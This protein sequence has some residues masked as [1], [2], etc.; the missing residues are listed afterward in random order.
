MDIPLTSKV[1]D[2]PITPPNSPQGQL[3]V[4]D[5]G[6][7]SLI[8]RFPAEV[9]SWSRVSARVEFSPQG[10]NV[11]GQTFEVHNVPISPRAQT[12]NVTLR[13]P[14]SRTRPNPIILQSPISRTRPDAN[15]LSPISRTYP[16]LESLE[17]THGSSSSQR[18]PPSPLE[19]VSRTGNAVNSL[20][21]ARP[22]ANVVDPFVDDDNEPVIVRPNFTLADLPDPV[23]PTTVRGSRLPWAPPRP[24]KYYVV[25][26]GFKIGIF[27]QRWYVHA[28][29]FTTLY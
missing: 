22:P 23:Y 8:F 21:A 28:H 29:L 13:S 11:L 19:Y 25:I 27:L 9:T 7:V 17:R 18:R 10:S 20:D 16:D 2:N 4:N 24:Q 3:H 26:K 1:E 5:T 6:D 15:M 14:V 12:R